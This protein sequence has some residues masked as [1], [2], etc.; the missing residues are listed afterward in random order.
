M[1]HIHIPDKFPLIQPK[2]HIKIYSP[3]GMG[4]RASNRNQYIQPTR[5]QT[6]AHF[7]SDYNKYDNNP[8]PRGS[9]YRLPQIN[10]TKNIVQHSDI[11]LSSFRRPHTHFSNNPEQRNSEFMNYSP[12][13]VSFASQKNPFYNQSPLLN[14]RRIS[15]ENINHIA[16][17]YN[18]NN[19]YRL[20]MNM[21]IDVP[22]SNQVNKSRPSTRNRYSMK[23]RELD[24]L[25]Y[26]QFNDSIQ[27]FD[28]DS[29]QHI[30]EQNCIEDTHSPLNSTMNSSFRSIDFDEFTRNSNHT[31]GPKDRDIWKRH[32][33]YAANRK[34][35]LNEPEK[36]NIAYVPYYSRESWR[37]I[38][39]LDETCG[40]VI[41]NISG[42][43]EAIVGK[44]KIRNLRNPENGG[45][46]YLMMEERIRNRE[47]KQ[48]VSSHAKRKAKVYKSNKYKFPK[49]V[50]R[51]RQG[52]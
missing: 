27:S 5:P 10:R 35:E 25:K 18:S 26:V 19:S 33:Y 20:N 4:S 14:T 36:D 31:D 3:R 45:Y 50:N 39:I 42:D 23:Q 13:E 46:D 47:K 37:K 8:T 34:Y 21:S 7:Q 49:F 28:H 38:P 29:R 48:T 12:R 41:P 52:N 11:E 32:E 40:S 2:K 17:K 30:F 15:Q 43:T 51:E 44:P 6:S 1:D 16:R 9:K 22:I 24:R